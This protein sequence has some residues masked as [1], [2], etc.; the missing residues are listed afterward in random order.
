[1]LAAALGTIGLREPPDARLIWIANTLALTE[2][3]CST[4]T[5]WKLALV[6]LLH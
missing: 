4:A 2:V 5:A 6:A 1:M 3:A